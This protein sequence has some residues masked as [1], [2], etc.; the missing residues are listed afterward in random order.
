[1]INANEFVSAIKLLQDTRGIS[2]EII[3]EALKQSMVNAY[4]KVTGNKDAMVK[5]TIDDKTGEIKVFNLKKVVEEVLDDALE[6]SLED[7][8]ENEPNAKID[9]LYEI[10]VS[11]DEE[12][13]RMAAL[14]VKQVLKQKIR[15]A[16]KQ[17]IYDIYIAKKDDIILG[18]VEKVDKNFCLINIGRTS[19]ILNAA[20]R[21]PN[22]EY[23]VNQQ[24]K[25]YVVGVDKGNQ[26]A[27][28]IV[29]R[30]DPGFL[31]RLFEQEIIEVYDG[32]VE[33]KSIAREPGERA[34]V[35]VFSRNPNVDAPGACIGPK[36][37]RIQKVSSQLA[38]EK[39][40]V[41]A[42][43]EHPELYIA[44]ALKP[45]EVLGMKIDKENTS[46][47][48]VVPNNALSL[49]IGKKGQNAR[50]A[51]KLT[52][53]KIDIKTVD[54]AFNEHI[55]YETMT[56]IKV[57]IAKEDEAKLFGNKEVIKPVVEEVLVDEPETVEE[58]EEV[59]ETVETPVVETP[60]VEEVIT[61]PVKTEPVK[62]VEVEK[63]EIVAPSQ[64][65][66]SLADLEKEIERERRSPKQPAYTPYKSFKDKDKDKDKDLKDKFGLDTKKDAPISKPSGYQMPVY[67]EDE[68]KAL[69]TAEEDNQ[70]QYD[71]E[72]DYD[73]F[74]KYYDK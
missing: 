15:E 21:I 34:K 30:T 23:Y 37:M 41:I 53:W 17:S 14:H 71:D 69:E 35:A 1:M 29:S 4:Q 25:V 36:G 58:Q 67:S 66:K 3:I 8:R 32:T 70:N 18:I 57:R 49:A 59:V 52:N 60:K 68:L 54:A 10:P 48:V 45:A 20:N 61:E 50:L 62:E 56:E 72:I 12:Y 27:Q 51:V 13:N 39:I 73:E 19:A 74:D 7:A 2:K 16:E 28:V 22:E 44:E 26:G 9:D 31:R 64:P 46:A 42:Y 11:I 24:I 38:G 55:D 43:N 5:V 33:I 6:I 47:V 63:V 65:L 40:D